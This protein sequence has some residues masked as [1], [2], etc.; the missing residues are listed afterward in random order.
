MLAAAGVRSVILA[1]DSG[2]RPIKD[3]VL[4]LA[5]EETWSI[6]HGQRLAASGLD[7]RVL[8]LPLAPGQEKADLDSFLLGHS[9]TRLQHL[10]DTAPNLRA[11]HR[12]LPRSLLAAAKLPPPGDYPTRRARPQRLDTGIEWAPPALPPPSDLTAMREAIARSVR[13][14]ALGGE[15]FL[16]LGHP[17]GT[18]KG[19]N[20]VLGLKA[21]LQ[22][23]A[24]PGQIIWAAPRK[25]Q[26]RDQ[27]GLELTPLHG[28]NPDNC[29]RIGEAQALSAKGYSVREALCR[30][31]CP[32]VDHCLY[33]R[34][35]GQEA[36]FFAP[37]PLL[38]ATGWWRDASVV[39]LDEFDPA[40]LTRVVTLTSADLAAM[41]RA[42]ACPHA[43]A[44]LRWV[45]QALASAADRQLT[46]DM[47]QAE[48]DAVARA[49]GLD[50]AATLAAACQGLPSE[51][52][53]LLLPGFP[54]GAGLADYEALPPNY[55][56]V[57]IERLAREQRA[58]L[59]GKPFTSRLEL[60]GGRLTLF[61]RIEHLVAQLA[62]P[63]Q[64]KV[65]LDATVSAPLLRAIFP[66]TP[67][68]VE[69]PGLAGGARVIQV[70]SRDWAKSG[71]R[72]ER[73]ER[74]YDEVA[75][76][77]RPA[78]PTLVVCTLEC[79]DGLRAAL[80]ARGHADAH[81]AHYGAL[82]GS[83]A[84]KGHDV[85]LAQVYHPN[86]DAIVREGRA[87]FADDGAPLDERVLTSE[88]ILADTSGGRWAVQ[89]PTFADTRLAALLENRREAEMLQCAMRGR[90][91]DHPEA[92]I[93]LLFGLPLPG[94]TP[95]LAIEGEASAE[96]NAGREEAVKARLVAA[97]RRLLSARARVIS[98][99][100]LAHETEASVVSVRKHW[101]YIA[102]CLG[103]RPAHQTHED[104]STQG[105]QRRVYRRMVLIRR[106]RATPPRHV[107]PQDEHRVDA[108]APQRTDHARNKQYIMC[109]IR[110]SGL[111]QQP[112]YRSKA[113]FEVRATGPPEGA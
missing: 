25:E 62:S 112:C 56:A 5:P 83:N 23:H 24:S 15:G 30:R 106:G 113:P 53:Q 59:A 91:L 1:Y 34:Q 77:I 18:G 47:L 4:Q 44:V 43:Q 6:R 32:H 61:L 48:L 64:P 99:E 10:I 39:I 57:L 38:Q 79:E 7:V 90:P 55:L 28:R 101:A 65:I 50:L 78:R 87:L 46:G 97:A 86:L 11:Y 22:A 29:R 2:P 13:D 49:E 12:S 68:Q 81:V 104:R 100:D 8:R 72:G 16:V 37:L 54:R 107:S 17:P 63:A 95:T 96:S 33:L 94:L 40:R 19:H 9:A 108:A 58:H 82:R 70:I 31:R 103:L 85:I 105:A 93:T 102:A 98:V 71:L 111:P 51:E 109:V 36:D 3:G 14:H 67:I 76:Q 92:Q 60:A 69:R 27:E 26:I 73:R 66:N 45:G 75:A 52:E 42:T 21:Y 110:A 80:K 84:Y 88:R 74:W 20:T 41:S 89:V 35:F